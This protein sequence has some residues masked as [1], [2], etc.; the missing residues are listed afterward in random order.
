MTRP[1]RRHQRGDADRHRRPRCDPPASGGL[2]AHRGRNRRAPLESHHSRAA[3]ASPGQWLELDE[4]GRGGP[5]AEWTGLALQVSLM[6][7]RHG[8]DQ[9]SWTRRMPFFGSTTPFP[10]KTRA[11]TGFPRACRQHGL[12]AARRRREGPSLTVGVRGHWLTSGVGQ[13]DRMTTPTVHPLTA[14]HRR[15][16]LWLH[17]LRRCP[18][19]N[20]RASVADKLVQGPQCRLARGG[21]ASML[22]PVP[23]PPAARE[24]VEVFSED[25]AGLF[26]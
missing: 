5:F 20:W 17:P 18:P 4:G 15:P 1:Q 13:M 25:E 11:R 6:G 19:G 2:P 3:C 10:N 22:S 8:D 16:G 12:V 26:C 23:G 9:V 7:G 14:R 24:H 21:W